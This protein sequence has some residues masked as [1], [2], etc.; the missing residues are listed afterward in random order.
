M[1]VIIE[2]SAQAVA[3]VAKECGQKGVRAL[4]VISDG[5]KE[6]GSRRSFAGN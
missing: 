5:F 1:A 6:S 4:V 2:F 3:K